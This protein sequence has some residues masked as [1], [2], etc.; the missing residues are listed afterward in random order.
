MLV[1]DTAIVCFHTL[2]VCLIILFKSVQIYEISLATKADVILKMVKME[3]NEMDQTEK[4]LAPKPDK[5]NSSP[6]PGFT[7]WERESA[8]PGCP[9][10]ST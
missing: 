7:R 5:L 3:T 8:L 4:A 10:T 1:I 2:L 6:V 9:L